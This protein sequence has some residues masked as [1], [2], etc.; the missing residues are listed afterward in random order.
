[1]DDVANLIA[2]VKQGNIDVYELIVRRFQDMAVGY[3]YA[4]LGDLQLAEDAAQEAFIAAYFE[5]PSLQEPQAFPGWFRRIV[6]KQIDRIRRKRHSAVSLEKLSNIAG[7][8]ADLAEI[9]VR[10]E[11]YDAILMAIQQLPVSQREVVTLFYIGA[12]SHNDISAFLDI[13]CS[14]V[15]MRLYHARKRLRSQLASLIEERLPDQRPSRDTR[16]VRKIMSF[17]VTAKQVPAQKIVSVTR[18]VFIGDLQAHLDGS[19]KRLMAY[20]QANN[21]LMSLLLHSA[22]SGQTLPGRNDTTGAVVIGVTSRCYQDDHSLQCPLRSSKNRC[23]IF[24]AGTAGGTGCTAQWWCS[25]RRPTAPKEHEGSEGCSFLF[26]APF[27]PLV[28]P[29]GSD[30]EVQGPDPAAAEAGFSGSDAGLALG[31]LEGVHV[32][33]GGG[34][35]LLHVV[36]GRLAAPIHEVVPQPARGVGPL[37]AVL[38]GG[39]GITEDVLGG[40]LDSPCQEIRPT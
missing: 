3:G 32:E 29:S 39:R 30:T 2:Q 6:V 1:M 7:E 22:G 18:Q 15:K 13:S 16:F 24:G 34:P 4:R 33:P 5:L 38:G 8:Q 14:T 9:I 37:V 27:A 10:Q 12:Y 36:G 40:A 17:Q 28:L 21:L 31:A 23:S 11:V 19:I 35:G 20:A 26:S 25:I